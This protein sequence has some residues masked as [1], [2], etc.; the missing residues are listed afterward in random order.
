M[1]IGRV[2]PSTECDSLSA[3]VAVRSVPRVALVVLELRECRHE[4]NDLAD[5]AVE[6]E[7]QRLL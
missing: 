4:Q 6:P 1:T 2:P 5:V 7:L 3:L